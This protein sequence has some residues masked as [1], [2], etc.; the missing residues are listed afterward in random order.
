MSITLP[1]GE[2]RAEN[3]VTRFL[4]TSGDWQIVTD[5]PDAA[6]PSCGYPERHRIYDVQ[7]ETA[8]LLADGCPSCGTSRMPAAMSPKTEGEG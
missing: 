8:D 3:I 6:C 1:T 7:V 2:K 5:G 4:N